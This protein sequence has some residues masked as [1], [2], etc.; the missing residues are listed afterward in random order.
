M[1][2]TQS[3]NQAKTEFLSHMSHELGTPLTSILG[4]AQLIE[5]AAGSPESRD[6]ASKIA[7]AGKHLGD[8]V[9]EALDISRID[10]GRLAL[11]IEPVSVA[12]LVVECLSIIEPFADRSAID[13]RID[14]AEGQRFVLADRRRIKQAL[15]N[16]L[17]NAVKYS[18][19]GDVV[20][21][22]WRPVARG[23]I[24]ISVADTGPGIEPRALERLFTPFERLGSVRK[25]SGTGLGLALTKRMA[26]AMGGVV[27]VDSTAGEGSTFWIEL[28]E[29][30]AP[31]A[32]WPVER[33]PDGRAEGTILYIEDN[34]TNVAVVSQILRDRAVE[35]IGV[36][37]GRVGLELAAH[38]PPDLIL[39]DQHLPDVEAREVLA[40]LR[41]NPETRNIP[42]VVLSAD[43]SPEGYEE[44][45]A[46]GARAYLTKPVDI[47]R[48]TG[49]VDDILGPTPDRP[50]GPPPARATRTA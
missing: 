4:Y 14:G 24:R 7:A 10:Q 21:V 22:S 1:E 30:A 27:G 18:A 13:V 43:A 40:R 5:S 48:L 34:E 29:T 3:A 33:R 42:V 32:R 26:E 23:R 17:S 49:L 6:Y 20:T 46:A 31:T 9:G 11:S 44:L 15:L 38:R 35:V 50:S 36:A 47:D 19:E 16:F 25:A 45:L 37:E 2:T 39:L 41:A 12:G 8:L 28:T